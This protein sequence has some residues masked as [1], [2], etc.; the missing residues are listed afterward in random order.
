MT[1]ATPI[2]RLVESMLSDGI[3]HNAIVRAIEAAE[4]GLHRRER[5][6]LVRGTRLPADWTPSE[7]QINYAAALHMLPDRISVETEKFRNYWTAKAGA[8][9]TKRDWDAT[10]RNWILTAMEGRHVVAANHRG[11]S[12]GA[13][14][15]AR[16]SK[17]G[18][19]AVLAGMGRLS[20]RLAHDRGPARPGD[21]KTEAITDATG[22][23]DDEHGRA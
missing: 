1:A 20:R 8:G 14:P 10:W 17:T 13:D 5:T 12:S 4:A 2:A 16:S 3:E 7:T 22:S 19:D 9:A 18:A 23:D 6:A 15:T 21:G 11:R